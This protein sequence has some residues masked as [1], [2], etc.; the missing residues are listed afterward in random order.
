MDR[1]K[2]DNET[3]YQ[4]A[5]LI[6]VV[7]YLVATFFVDIEPLSKRISTVTTLVAAVAFWLQFKRSEKLNE[8]NF[9]KDLNNQFVTN[10]DMTYVEHEL[11]L[12]YNQYVAFLGNRQT[13]TANEIEKL[14][15][16]INQSRTKEDCQKMINYLVY[17]E[18]LAAL[19]GRN[20]IHLDVIDDLFSYRF[21][22]AVNNPVVQ[23]NELLPYRDFYQGIFKLS[24]KWAANHKERGIPIPM[25]QF[26]LNENRIKRYDK[27]VRDIE[28][29]V[30]LAQGSDNKYE[31]ASCIYDTDR[32]IYPETFGDYKEPAVKGISRLIGMDNSL[33]DY[34]NLLVARYNGRVCGICLFTTGANEWNDELIAERL[35]GE[36]LN[37][38]RKEGFDH[39]VKE[40]F[41]KVVQHDEGD[42]YV[43]LVACCV[44]DGYQRKGIAG[45]MLKKLIEINDGKTIRLTVLSDN[46]AAI[47]LYEKN[48]FVVVEDDVD[49]FGP[50]GLK[51]PKC[52]IMER[53][54]SLP[55]DG[56]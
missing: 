55:A 33:F 24:E 5:I 40:Y 16:G 6:I 49:G 7:L 42:D 52:K 18:S 26:I 54:A 4:V 48:G 51:P 38:Q 3:K 25:E 1:R 32:Y 37:A 44:D 41:R 35:G 22:L 34:K 19:E 53:K 43:E 17:L 50:K 56:D 31:I 13:L 20:I 45:K 30:D 27:G 10:K 9:I 8:A 29:K 39:G 14:H 28:Y 21:F 11:E 36:F 12:Y 46:E 15:L 47:E 2:K 23:E